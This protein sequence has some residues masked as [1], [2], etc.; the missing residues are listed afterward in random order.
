M[1]QLDGSVRGESLHFRHGQIDCIDYCNDVRAMEHLCRYVFAAPL[2]VG[3][4][5][6]NVACGEGYGAFILARHGATE[7]VGV[8]IAEE[9][10]AVAQKRFARDGVEFL[11]GDAV[12]LSGTLGNRAPFDVVISFETIEHVSDPRRFLDGVRRM[13][14][15]YGVIV[16]SCS[17]DALNNT[18][19]ASQHDLKTYTLTDFQEL[20]TDVLG[21]AA[22]WYLGTPLQGVV[23]AEA[24]SSRRH[25]D[26]RDPSLLADSLKTS[27]GHVLPAQVTPESC[28]FYVGIWG[29]P[30][31]AVHVAVPVSRQ[32]CL[33]P[34]WA[35]EL[36][37][38]RVAFLEEQIGDLRRASIAERT[39]LS[40]QSLKERV[41]SLE[42]QIAEFERVSA[43]EKDRLEEAHQ[44]IAHLRE[45][46]SSRGYRLL[47]RYY[48]LAG[49]PITGPMIQL[50]RRV[51]RSVLHL[52]RRLCAES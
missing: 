30:G 12:D 31:D 37:K 38:E 27:S 32:A 5:V 50:M 42:G 29:S 22:R 44:S 51:A 17:N 6:L 11:V 21:T 25:D 9:A 34:W 23:I 2:C 39:R 14:T 20:T 24:S 52:I 13:L 15:P 18:G 10:I 28:A 7:V 49:A 16:L 19:N 47:Q 4:R 46:E 43:V 41:A 35:L 45:I 33:E 36:F 40:T 48:V 1:K 26:S 3:K 8:D